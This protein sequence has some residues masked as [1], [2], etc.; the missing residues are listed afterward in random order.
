MN[1]N[2]VN[3]YL[4]Q[5]EHP[6]KA[7]VLQLRNYIKTDFPSLTEIIKWNAPS[8]QYNQLDFLTFNLAKPKDI[9]LILHRGA[10]NKE[11][12]L[13]RLIEDQS[14]LLQWAANDR[15]IITFTKSDE[16][17]NHQENLKSIIQNWITKL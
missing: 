15:A 17:T 11:A 8:Y 5:L 12:S 16:I 9:K 6:L 1:N 3:T 13:T 4:E 7:E 2:E 14:G 10:K